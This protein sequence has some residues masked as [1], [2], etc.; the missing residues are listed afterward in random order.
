MRTHAPWLVA[1][2]ILALL[3][4]RLPLAGQ[5]TP[6]EVTWR[7]QLGDQAIA[8]TLSPEPDGERLTVTGADLSRLTATW[9]PVEGG[10]V[11]LERDL[12]VEDGVWRSGPLALAAG[13]RWQVL[14]TGTTIG[15][16][17][18]LV[19]SDWVRGDDGV[20]RP[21]GV[22]SGGLGALIGQVNRW[23]PAALPGI[24][25]LMSAGWLWQTARR[26]Q[27]KQPQ[28]G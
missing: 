15:D 25:A 10:G 23:G 13:Q 11:I 28:A 16:D 12:R 27:R 8:A 7:G 20:L 9:I 6:E 26:I 19:T 22:P 2:V 4:N 21:E 1:L 3:Y 24:M 14:L 17:R 5:P 18:R